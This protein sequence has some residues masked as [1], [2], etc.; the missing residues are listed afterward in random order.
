MKLSTIK[1]LS[2]AITL[3]LFIAN[4]NIITPAGAEQIDR[5][6]SRVL[7]AIPSVTDLNLMVPA[8]ERMLPSNLPE[9]SITVEPFWSN[10]DRNNPTTTINKGRSNKARLTARQKS[11]L[12]TNSNLS[13]SPTGEQLTR[14]KSIARRKK[15]ISINIETSTESISRDS[16]KLR[17]SPRQKIAT[18]SRPALSGNYLRLVRDPNHGTNDIGNPIY[19]LEAYVDGQRYQTFDTVSGTATTQDFDRHRGRN[20]APLPDGLYTV[21]DRVIPG[22]VAEVGKTFIGISP[23]FETGRS[24]L[25]IHLDP[26]FNKRNGYDGT[27]GCIGVTTATD[28]DAI[29]E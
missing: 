21:S 11:K 13:T 2:K 6:R 3:P 20:F 29:D 10:P 28:R 14:N 8:P 24:D 1:L 19:I 25:G 18:G 16:Q 12:A 4:L 26:S 5:S 22:N 27:A 9:E 23:R 15:L 17:S 7:G